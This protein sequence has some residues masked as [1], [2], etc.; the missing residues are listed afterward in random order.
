MRFR[1]PVA[2]PATEAEFCPAADGTGGTVLADGGVQAVVFPKGSGVLGAGGGGGS[3]AGVAGGG[4]STAIGGTVPA[5]A[6][7]TVNGP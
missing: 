1:K 7:G 4:G 5:L 6:K 3:G 2:L